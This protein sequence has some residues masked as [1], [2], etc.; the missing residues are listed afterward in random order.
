[1]GTLVS[2][3]I[4]D[5]LTKAVFLSW[6]SALEYTKNTHI[7]I[8]FSKEVKMIKVVN[9]LLHSLMGFK[10]YPIFHSTLDET[11]IIAI[12]RSPLSPKSLAYM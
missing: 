10:S 7:E 9:R 6:G 3:C 11:M 5:T 4:T 1:M 8:E 12:K 2:I